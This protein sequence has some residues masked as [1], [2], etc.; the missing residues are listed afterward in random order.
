[1]VN[2]LMMTIQEEIDLFFSKNGGT[3]VLLENNQG[4][5]HR[6]KNIGENEFL[7]SEMFMYRG[8]SWCNMQSIQLYSMW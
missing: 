2:I 6:L 1:M 7:S 8:I 5:I 3:C 4:R